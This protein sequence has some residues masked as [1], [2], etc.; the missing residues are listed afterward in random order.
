VSLATTGPAGSAVRPVRQPASPPR[1]HM[2]PAPVSRGR[3][4]R[5]PFVMVVILLLVAGLGGLLLLNVLLA[6][7]SFTVQDLT[8]QVADLSD[9]EQALQ[10][11][12]AALDSPKRLARQ[13]SA[14]GMVPV[15][16]PAFLRERDGRILGDPVT[17][18]APVTP[19]SP[20]V[21]PTKSASPGL[22]TVTDAKHPSV[23][24]TTDGNSGNDAAH[25][26]QQQGGSQPAGGKQDKGAAG[27]N[28]TH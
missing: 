10:Q 13:A 23:A 22:T 25:G 6:Q 17:A 20:S 11:R 4:P 15:V 18:V 26:S 7:G 1:R 16:N 14:M 24:P 3:A 2:R 9:R 27:G 5:A 28:Q 19:P 8:R 21:A 12:V